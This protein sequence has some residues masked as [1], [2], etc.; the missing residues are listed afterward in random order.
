MR[1]AAA[2]MVAA[3]TTTA[4][5]HTDRSSQRAVGAPA[6]HRSFIGAPGSPPKTAT[7]SAAEFGAYTFASELNFCRGERWIISG[8]MAPLWPNETHPVLVRRGTPIEDRGHVH[9]DCGSL[10]DRL[11]LVHGDL[12]RY[13]TAK[14]ARDR[15]VRSDDVYSVAQ[16]AAYEQRQRAAK[17]EERRRSAKAIRERLEPVA[18]PAPIA[19][20]G[21]EDGFAALVRAGNG[22]GKHYPCDVAK[23]ERY[24]EAARRAFTA[25]AYES[26]RTT[27]YGGVAYTDS[28]VPQ[29]H[30]DRVRGDALLIFSK[31]ELRMGRIT[32]GKNDADAAAASY[33]DCASPDGYSEDTV[34][35]CRSHRQE[36]HDIAHG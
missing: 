30:P 14:N 23:A 7:M 28:C 34:A 1:Y 21:Y 33:V 27:A 29:L 26:A 15:Y 10:D 18:M 35:Y 24:V 20:A 11:S 32:A 31:A 19:A 12:V 8:T 2:A 17:A 3:L 6:L 25:R 22:L 13:R 5:S 4:C 16:Y 9:V 36:A